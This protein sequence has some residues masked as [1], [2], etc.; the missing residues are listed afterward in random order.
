MGGRLR[1][2]HGSNGEGGIAPRIAGSP[3]LADPGGIEDIVRNGRRTMPAVGSGWSEEQMNALTTYL[4]ES[5]PSG[6][7]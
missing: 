1:Q 6:S 3:A 7:G 5:P 2:C 4:Q